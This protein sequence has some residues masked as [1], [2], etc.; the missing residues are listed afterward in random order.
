LK[1][2]NGDRIRQIRISLNL[3]QY[4]LSL[5]LGLTVDLIERWES[6]EYC[7][8]NY[9]KMVEDLAEILQYPN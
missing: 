4:E 6:G 9:L 5:L 1:L 3:T 2:S 7:S 8:V